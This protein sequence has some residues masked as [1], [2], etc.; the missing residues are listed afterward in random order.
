MP[1]FF[2]LIT[3]IAIALPAQL[4][5]T[6]VFGRGKILHFGPI[7]VS[8]VAAYGTFLTLNATGSF[9]LGL[10][11][12]VLMALAFS[13]LFAWLSFRLDSDG[14]GIMSIAVYLA[15][16]AVVLNWTSLT[17]GALGLPRIPRVP[18]ADSAMSF[19]LLTTGACVLWTL[20]FLWLDR[21]K[22]AR[23]VSALA[24]GEW[25]AKALGISRAGAH[26]AAFVILGL[27]LA[28]DNFFYAQY[29]HLLHP[30][31]YYFPAFVSLLMITVAGK[32]GS[33][34]GAIIATILLSL[35]KEGLRFLPFPSAVLGPLRLMLFGIILLA[36][37][38][39]QRDTL[40]PKKRTI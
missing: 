15:L 38:W 23:Q 26:I 16:F 27:T 19:A 36:A 32:P 22:L 12:G 24:E 34:P 10:C 30:S 37:V 9:L 4:G 40:F 31:D 5:Y 2:H 33:T 29:Y 14:L 21:T 39:I 13:L 17:R 3:V 11:A 25:H 28:S 8:T 6:F 18:F 1:F 7:G 35:L 20:F